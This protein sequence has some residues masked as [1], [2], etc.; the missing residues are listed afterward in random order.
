MHTLTLTLTLTSSH[1]CESLPLPHSSFA[2]LPFC[3]THLQA[4]VVLFACAERG[5]GGEKHAV[6]GVHA[7]PS[8]QVE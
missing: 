1:P 6:A 8:P 7:V 5:G 4:G 2:Q 3:T